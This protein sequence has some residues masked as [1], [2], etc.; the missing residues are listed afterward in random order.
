M[1]RGVIKFFALS[2]L[3]S[4][5]AFALL[6]FGAG[7]KDGGSFGVTVFVFMWGPFLAA[8]ILAPKIW[9]DWK[10]KLKIRPKINRMF[11]LAWF[12]PLILLFVTLLAGQAIGL[13]VVSYHDAILDPDNPVS[14]QSYYIMF[15][16]VYIFG[17]LFNGLFSISEELGFRGFALASLLPSF[18]FWKTSLI[19]GMFWG[20]WHTPLIVSGYNYPGFAVSGVLMITAVTVSLS[21]ILNYL[22]LKSGSIW[23][24]CFFHGAFNYVAGISVVM[25]PEAGFP[26]MGMIGIPGVLV[27][28][29]IS[30]IIYL[31]CNKELG[32]LT[33]VKPVAVND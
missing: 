18:G 23:A 32:K 21:P 28:V 4:W 29:G 19:I 8:I 27:F 6:Y 7:L 15:V 9:T 22:T 25:M 20:L 31:T 2:Y 3:L 16:L 13:D 12:A 11:V 30:T 33:F 10:K 26:F 17:G 1:S 5:G 14:I 24:A